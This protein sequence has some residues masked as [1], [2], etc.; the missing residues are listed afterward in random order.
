MQFVHSG[1]RKQRGGNEQQF[2]TQLSIHY[3]TTTHQTCALCYTH[4]ARCLTLCYICVLGLVLYYTFMKEA[5]MQLKLR[6]GVPVCLVSVSVCIVTIHGTMG[7]SYGAG[8]KW[9]GDRV[10]TTLSFHHSSAVQSRYPRT[11]CD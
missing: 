4:H 7:W 8:V 9:W 6:K 3:N 11:C 2:T 1:K 10:V 5:K